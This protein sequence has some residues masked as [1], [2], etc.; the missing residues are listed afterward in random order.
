MQSLQ[1]KTGKSHKVL[2]TQ[3]LVDSVLVAKDLF[4]DDGDIVKLYLGKRNP[5]K[6]VEYL[7]SRLF[8]IKVKLFWICREFR[9]PLRIPKEYCYIPDRH[10]VRFLWNVRVIS[11]K[12]N[13]TL[14]DYFQLSKWMSLHFDNEY[15]DLP[16]MRFH[17]EKCKDQIGCSCEIRNCRFNQGAPNVR[18]FQLESS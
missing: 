7:Y 17:Q 11:R 3:D 5:K 14:D 4:S 8:G 16:F 1:Q 13:F 2:R 15:F 9:Q 18:L 10:V 12:G 6:F